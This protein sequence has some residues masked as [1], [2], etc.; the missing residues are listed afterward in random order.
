[1]CLNYADHLYPYPYSI[2][3]P[4]IPNPPPPNQPCLLQPRPSR[5]FN[6]I[7]TYTDKVIPSIQMKRYNF[8]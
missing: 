6:V 5:Q 2:I 8:F 4:R 1:M 7:P 3:L